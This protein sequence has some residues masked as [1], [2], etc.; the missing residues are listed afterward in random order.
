MK[1]KFLWVIALCGC[2]LRLAKANRSANIIHN[3]TQMP[4]ARSTGGSNCFW[5]VGQF[6]LD[7]HGA[8]AQKRVILRFLKLFIPVLWKGGGELDGT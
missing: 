7:I 4:A 3:N 1:L 8:V 5:N 6:L 2:N